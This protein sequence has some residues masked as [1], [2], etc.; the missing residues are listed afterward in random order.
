VWVVERD[1][2]EY[3]KRRRQELQLTRQKVA[4]RS[5]LSYAY[6]SQ[7]ESGRKSR[8][9]STV[10]GQLAQALEV[11]VDDLADQVGVPLD[12]LPP[13]APRRT[14]AGSD[15]LQWHTNPAHVR[16]DAM[17]AFAMDRVE[18]ATPSS[19]LPAARSQVLPALERLLAPY[20]PTT[21]LALLN[22]LQQQALRELGA[23]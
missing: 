12:D 7:L 19:E 1:F 22:E 5:G 4:D 2:G 14:S 16:S 17:V 21:R 23:G 3:L 6:L 15:A 18:S 8:P 11:T 20:S 13:S 10:L 9:S